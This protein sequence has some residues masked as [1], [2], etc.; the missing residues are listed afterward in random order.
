M[1]TASEI[2]RIA[3]EEGLDAAVLE[4]D[5]SVEQKSLR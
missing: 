5:Y 2:R 4:K 1:I 3:G